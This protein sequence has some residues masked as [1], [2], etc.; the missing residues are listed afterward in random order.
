MDQIRFGT[1]GW[2]AKVAETFTFPNVRRAAYGLGI[3]LR[4]KKKS[5]RVFVGYDT[6]FFSDKFARAAAEVLSSLGHR[7]TLASRLLPTPA[8]SLAV[9]DKKADAGVMIT[10][11]HNSGAYNGFKIKL[12]PG[13]SA[14]SSFTKEV[15]ARIPAVPPVFP[16][17]AP[18]A[19]ADWLP[20]YLKT[21]KSK[22]NL[23]ALRAAGLKIV[24][25]SMHGVGS[26]HF[27]Q[28]VS[29]GKTKVKTVAGN[30][31]V[32][33]GGR[34]PEPIG[35]N[36]GPLSKAIKEWKADVGFATDGDGDRVGMM[37]EKGNYVDVHKLHALLLYHLYI[38]RGWRGG[39]VKTISGTLMIERMAR[40]WGI[41]VFETPIGFKH[42]GGVMLE[43]DILLGLEESGGIAV[44]GHLAER[45]GLLSA[46]LLLEA[47]VAL[48]KS[49]TGAID[50]LQKE[51]GP[52]YSN[53]IDLENISFDRQAKVLAKL[54]KSP[55]STIAGHRVTGLNTLDGVKLKL[56][57]GWLL[58]RASGTEPLLR[59]YAEAPSPRE[60]KALLNA[61]RQLA[62]RG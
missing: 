45:D 17:K 26:T 34:Q 49:V 55:P 19:S 11:S 44:K 42:I 58:V 28:L 56:E 3:A 61:A 14:P 15:E 62:V 21:V 29:G 39:I 18:I 8:L 35:P 53:R 52:F 47:L 59:L 36:L 27:E 9:K 50:F 22:V 51:F 6:R 32:F 25:D 31:D 30:R 16:R 37:D 1:D 12:P 10:A 48:G 33:F 2:R 38:N 40:R 5:C 4:K 20:F 24:V 41:R 13:V 57:K 43:N 54:K 60:V 46:L 23:P 7:V